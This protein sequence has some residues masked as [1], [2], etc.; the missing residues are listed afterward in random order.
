M[1]GLS[2]EPSSFG[3]ALVSNAADG[4]AIGIEVDE[5]LGRRE[6]VVRPLPLPLATL[7]GYSGAAI[8]D[9]GSIV[10]VLDPATLPLG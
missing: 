8:M 9:D 1:L 10:L 3:M 2:A 7:G 5:V 6:L 4:K